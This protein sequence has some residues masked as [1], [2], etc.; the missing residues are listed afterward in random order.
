MFS[1]KD[2]EPLAYLR[3]KETASADITNHFTVETNEFKK[4]LQTVSNLSWEENE[5]YL[6]ITED[7]GLVI[8]DS[9][10]TN[11]ISVP[12][13]D[14][15]IDKSYTAKFVRSIINEA[16][17]PVSTSKVTLKWKETGMTYVLESLLDDGT[18]L[19]NVFVFF[20]SSS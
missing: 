5:I 9:N 1:L 20:I 18:V 16:F 19:D 3:L 13:E 6:D 2:A 8:R 17:H 11:K 14:L 7:D 10:K 12:I 4:A 15:T